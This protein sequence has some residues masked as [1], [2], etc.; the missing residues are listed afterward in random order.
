MP[1]MSVAGMGMGPGGGVAGMGGGGPVGGNAR[2]AQSHPGESDRDR[3]A[4]IG[5]LLPAASLVIDQKTNEFDF[6]DDKSRTR[7]FY[8]DGRKLQKSKDKDKRQEVVARWDD[9]HL[10]SEE[11]TPHGGK[12]SRKFEL[13]SDGRQLYET[14]E[15]DS[16]RIYAPTEI[17]YVYDAA[18]AGK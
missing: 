2:A 3:E 15:V 14:I 18:P 9:G 13:S 8:T 12:L 16:S 17:R 5:Y 6:T 10:V 1:G 11:Q 7:V 4:R